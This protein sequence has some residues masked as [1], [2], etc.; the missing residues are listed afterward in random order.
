MVDYQKRATWRVLPLRDYDIYTMHSLEDAL[1]ELVGSG[2][3]P[4]TVVFSTV[5][6]PAVSISKTQ[7][8]Y[9]DV[10]VALCRSAG[11]HLARRKTGG[12]SVYLD[13]NYMIVSMIGKPGDFQAY[14]QDVA[15]VYRYF[16]NRLKGT[17]RRLFN[18]EV[19]VEHVN[20]I[21]VDNAKIGGSAQRH[22]NRAVIAHGYIRYEKSWELPLQYLKIGG[23][24]LAPYLGHMNLFT[25]SV[26]EHR[27]LG[28][29]EFYELFRD[30][31]L[32]SFHHNFGEL[33]DAELAL[34]ETYRKR[35]TDNSWIHKYR[36]N[37]TSRGNSDFETIR[38][39]GIKISQGGS[40]KQ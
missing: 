23:R 26:K 30:I 36:P 12:R 10:D 4:P 22:D 28:Y 14:M 38:L 25:T 5:D 37:Y 8:L 13:R 6:P 39:K 18:A 33:T 2:Q 20:D 1:Y 29:H 11:V 32:K 16:C 3:A 9:V 35:H 17:L 24:S 15:Q 40:Q 19:T 31:L 7:N 21:M 27:S 34:V